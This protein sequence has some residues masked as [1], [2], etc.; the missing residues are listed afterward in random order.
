MQGAQARRDE[1]TLSQML[2][3]MGVPHEL[4]E[5]PGTSRTAADAAAEL[6]VPVSLI[7]KSL[8]CLAD[9][10]L[11]LA[12]V[13]GDRELDLEKLRQLTGARRCRLA[14]RD[15]VESATGYAVGAV[16]P[17]GLTDQVRVMGDERLRHLGAVYCG[18]GSAR[19]MLHIGTDILAS[20]ARVEWV[21]LSKSRPPDGGGK[22]P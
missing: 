15:E 9:D 14:P 1:N 22:S 21:D 12:M 2:E 19:H 16:A 17:V 3:R 13:P 6:D 18:G 8:L 7:V 10:A 4:I 20:I 11:V 5:V